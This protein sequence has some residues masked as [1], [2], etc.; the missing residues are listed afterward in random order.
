MPKTLFLVQAAS[1]IAVDSIVPAR[2]AVVSARL[3]F[4][5][6]ARA[7]LAL[8]PPLDAA[9]SIPVVRAFALASVD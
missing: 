8:R 9:P 5:P 1:F 2:S 3:G 6:I 7:E 4:P